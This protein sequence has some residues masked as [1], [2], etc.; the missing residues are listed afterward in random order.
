MKWSGKYLETANSY[1]DKRCTDVG[2]TLNN[3]R[4]T[5]SWLKS[6]HDMLS[7]KQWG[8]KQKRQTIWNCPCQRVCRLQAAMHAYLRINTQAS[9]GQK[10]NEHKHLFRVVASTQSF[11]L[12]H[13]C[14]RAHRNSIRRKR[15]I[16]L[17]DLENCTIFYTFHK[18]AYM[19][20]RWYFHVVFRWFFKPKLRP[21][22]H[23]DG[24]VGNMDS[25]AI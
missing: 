19:F 25:I 14:M 16:C 23:I 18:R 21:M 17:W 12:P 13:C 8:W 2:Q 20:K 11:G 15:T 22:L 1:L 4:S 10:W 7:P 3:Y 24:P 9:A 5:R 6:Y